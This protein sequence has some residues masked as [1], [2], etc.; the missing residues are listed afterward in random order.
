MGNASPTRFGPRPNEKCTYYANYLYSSPTRATKLKSSFK[1]SNSLA[2]ATLVRNISRPRTTWTKEGVGVAGVG[3][4]GGGYACS[5]VCGCG[6]LVGGWAGER[7]SERV[8]VGF[9]TDEN[10]ALGGRAGG[11]VCVCCVLC[12]VCCMLCVVRGVWVLGVGSKR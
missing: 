2:G 5:C 4:G 6:G 8:G 12:V 10:P 1:R 9:C 3:G 11:R 7:V